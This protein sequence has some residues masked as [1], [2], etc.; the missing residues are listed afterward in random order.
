MLKLQSKLRSLDDGQVDVWLTSLANIRDEL[1]QSY[2]QLL[3]AAERDRWERYVS[4]DAKLQ[5]LVARALVRTTLSLYSR[6]PEDAW[7][8]GT[9]RY[10]RPHVS[11]P[12]RFSDIQFNV[13][14]TSGLVICAVARNCVIGIDVENMRRDLDVGSLAPA[15]FSS[16]ELA[17]L[18]EATSKDRRDR[19]FSYWTLKEA[20]IKARGMGLSL[21]LDGFWFEL[22]G[23]FPRVKFTA[24]CPDDPG[25]WRFR[26]HHPTDEHKIALAVSSTASSL[27][28]RFLWAVPLMPNVNIM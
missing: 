7:Q 15:V 8:F 13:S 9:N 19:F 3:N 28:V 26:Q 21:A 27:D 22:D 20:Y 25:R 18:A 24:K 2:Q 5:Y 23:S 16:M 1:Q 17:G 10:G 12:E 14:H 4:K 11:K 6:I